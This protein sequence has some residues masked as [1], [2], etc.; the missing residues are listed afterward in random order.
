MTDRWEHD[1]YWRSNKVSVK[2]SQEMSQLGKLEVKQKHRD[3]IAKQA[4]DLLKGKTRWAP[5]W[6]SL[7]A[8]AKV[9]QGPLP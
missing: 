7:P 9:L 4:Q 8:D 2:L 6:Q 3:S 1:E 5:T